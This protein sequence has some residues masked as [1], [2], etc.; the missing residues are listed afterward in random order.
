MNENNESTKSPEILLEIL[1]TQQ[2]KLRELSKKEGLSSDLIQRFDALR[3]LLDIGAECALVLARPEY[4]SNEELAKE[5]TEEK[6]T[7]PDIESPKC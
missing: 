6:E 2:E 1:H 7:E 4:Q 3:T 5:N